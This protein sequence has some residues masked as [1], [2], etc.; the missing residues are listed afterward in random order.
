MTKQNTDPED[1]E[2]PPVFKSWKA[3]Y[4]FVILTSVALF[5]LFYLLTKMYS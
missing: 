4:W 1:E 2:K 5:I 3:A